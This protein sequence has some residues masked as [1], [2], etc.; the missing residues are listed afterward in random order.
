MY[1][2]SWLQAFAAASLTLN[3]FL[4]GL[5]GFAFWALRTSL[6]DRPAAKRNDVRTQPT[7]SHG[8]GVLARLTS[9]QLVQEPRPKQKSWYP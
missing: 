9:D 8:P 4:V 3:F 1:D 7:A 2:V 5:L 6:R